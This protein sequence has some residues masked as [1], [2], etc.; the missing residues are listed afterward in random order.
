MRSTMRVRRPWNSSRILS[1]HG[2]GVDGSRDGR[3]IRDSAEGGG[4]E[5]GGDGRL[6]WGVVVKGLDLFL[7]SFLSLFSLLST[8]LSIPTHKFQHLNSSSLLSL[9]LS[10]SSTFLS[11]PTHKLQDIKSSLS[12][13]IILLFFSLSHSTLLSIHTYTNFR[14]SPLP[15]SPL[16][17]FSF[18]SSSL[19]SSYL[20][21]YI[22]VY[23]SLTYFSLLL[24]LT[25]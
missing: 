19:L 5:G 8:F 3:L 18:C 17:S 15:F 1:H 7:L 20:S 6:V 11:I 23:L 16:L 24:F 14:T 9:I 4:R 13:F 21:Y 10:L 22:Y 12:S 25:S 2:R